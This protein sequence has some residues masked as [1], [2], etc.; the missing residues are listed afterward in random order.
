MGK[1]VQKVL[2]N[3]R[4]FL[5]DVVVI[6]LASSVVVNQTHSLE[7]AKVSADGRLGNS[8]YLLDVAY[9]S[10]A[11]VIQKEEDLKTGLVRKTLVKP[12]NV[13]H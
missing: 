11:E 13:F 7:E 5:Y 1:A 12:F 3:V 4:L 8:E 6:P 2:N 10:F 9:A